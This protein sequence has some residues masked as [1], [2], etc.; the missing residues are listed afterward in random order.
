MDSELSDVSKAAGR[1]ALVV[2]VFLLLGTLPFL[3]A[4]PQGDLAP[5]NVA[6]Y[7]PVKQVTSVSGTVRAIVSMPVRIVNPDSRYR[8]RI[9][10]HGSGEMVTVADWIAAPHP[11]GWTVALQRVEYEDG[12]VTYRFP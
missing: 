9:E 6:L 10:L 5:G 8:Y 11:V 12:A 4:T 3:V 2:L 1:T 7:G